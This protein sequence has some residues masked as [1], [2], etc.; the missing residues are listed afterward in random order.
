MKRSE[1]LLQHQ[2]NS[3]GGGLNERPSFRCAEISVNNAGVN[4]CFHLAV[5]IW[6]VNFWRVGR[7]GRSIQ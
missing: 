1:T 2:N 6:A 5:L 3:G 4:W 7:A